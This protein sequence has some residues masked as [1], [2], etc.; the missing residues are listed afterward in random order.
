MK[1]KRKWYSTP[2]FNNYVAI[3]FFQ[4]G[5]LILKVQQCTIPLF[6]AQSSLSLSSLSLSLARA[7]SLALSVE[8]CGTGALGDFDHVPVV[9]DLAQV[10][11]KI[12]NQASSAPWCSSKLLFIFYIQLPN[13]AFLAEKLK[14]KCC[15]IIFELW[16]TCRIM[17]MYIALLY[18]AANC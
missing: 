3:L 13:S 17:R 5:A 7:L 16:G 8:N 1:E 18:Y 4:L 11:A 6:K 10:E 14:K 9:E 2:Q 15:D 12:K